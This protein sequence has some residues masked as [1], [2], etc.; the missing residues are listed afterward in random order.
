MK[1]KTLKDE[2]TTPSTITMQ[3]P[4][5]SRFVLSTNKNKKNRNVIR[6]LVFQ[7]IDQISSGFFSPNNPEEFRDIY[8][9]LMYHDRFFCL[10]DYDDYMNAQERVNEAYK[11]IIFITAL[12]NCLNLFFPITM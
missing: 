12:L 11:V 8:N 6:L 3:T 4:S 2:A 7:V 1:S 10:A 5:L 9:N